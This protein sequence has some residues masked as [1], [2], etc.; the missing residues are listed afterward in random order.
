MSE[1]NV[2]KI[3][4]AVVLLIAACVF[5]FRDRSPKDSQ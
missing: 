3:G 1:V 4:I 2:L 5:Y